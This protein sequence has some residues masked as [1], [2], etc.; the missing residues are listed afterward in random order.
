MEKLAIFVIGLTIGSFLGGYIINIIKDIAIKKLHNY[1]EK[2][3][4]T[5]KATS[6]TQRQ[7]IDNLQDEVAFL[8][9][10]RKLAFDKYNEKDAELNE[11]REKHKRDVENILIKY[12][13]WHKE[14]GF[15]S[16]KKEDINEFMKQS[17]SK[18]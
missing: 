3:Q 18:I 2:I 6:V 14:Q 7:H 10:E 1:I 15:A 16:H 9:S 17:Y 13:N 4:A 8:K 12:H 11:L 5:S